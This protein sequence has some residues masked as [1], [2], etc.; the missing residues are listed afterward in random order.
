MHYI[1]FDLEFNQD[2]TSVRAHY[3]FEIIQIGAIKLDQQLNTLG[4]FNRFIKPTFYTEISS[5]I[6]ELTGIT[7]EQLQSESIFPD[8]YTDFIEFIGETE[9]H[10][11]I[12]GMS[13]IK[14]L[15]RNIDGH[16]LNRK[17]LS[18]SYINLQPYASI[19]LELPGKNLLGLRTTVEAL[20]LPITLD[21]HNALHD[22]FYTAEIF[23]KIMNASIQPKFYDPSFVIVKPRQIKREIDFPKLLEQFKKMYA[24][25]M[26]QEEQEIIILAYKMG[27]T[28]QFL[29]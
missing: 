15:F 22:A 2:F 25:E 18:R 23:K 24:R 8:V 27:K 16:Q 3:P 9:T 26:T 13:D 20:N 10:F 19:Y 12:W 21:F 5:F 28:N 17:S 7:T 1:V 14:E 6:T 29:K 11:C 4:T